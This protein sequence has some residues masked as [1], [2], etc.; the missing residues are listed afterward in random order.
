V[1]GDRSSPRLN[2]RLE[3][4]L[5]QTV[6]GDRQ[7]GPVRLVEYDP[8]WPIRFAR[9]R[10][11]LAAAL[12]STAMT[13]EDIGSTAVPG[14]AAKPIIDVLLT[15][16]DPEDERAYAPALLDLGYELRVRE[17]GHR[18]FRPPSRDA[19]VHVWAE[20]SRE[21]RDHLLFRDRLRQSA[22]DR[23]A[24]A[25]LKRELAAEDWSDVNYYAEAKGAFINEILKR[26]RRVADA[27]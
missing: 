25:Q 10:E 27:R 22:T 18:M 21:H 17:P 14:L 11:S 7:P 5:A 15:I 9:I 2:T 24:Y 26:A 13:I 19:H 3:R 23:D 12:A 20:G 6:I 4:R 16:D 1:P 8:D